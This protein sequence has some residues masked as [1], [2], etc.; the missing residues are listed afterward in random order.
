MKM[1]VESVPVSAE[2][3]RNSEDSDENCSPLD[4]SCYSKREL[5]GDSVSLSPAIASAYPRFIYDY[6]RDSSSPQDSDDSDAKSHPLGIN[7]KAY[8][9]SL[10]KRY[11][12]SA[13]SVFPLIKL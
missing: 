10:M 13:K 11:R 8:K 6:E 2:A 7:P 5:K 1:E 9:K 4:L 12:K 3:R